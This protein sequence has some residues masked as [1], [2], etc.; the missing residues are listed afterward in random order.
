MHASIAKL[1]E[2]VNKLQIDDASDWFNRLF[3]SWGI[4]DWMT[5]ILKTA[6]I[7]V[8]SIVCLLL[9]L[10][11]ILQYIQWMIDHTVKAILVV[12]T[13]KEIVEDGYS[14]ISTMNSDMDIIQLVGRKPWE[15]KPEEEYR[16][17]GLRLSVKNKGLCV[18]ITQM[19]IIFVLPKRK[20]CLEIGTMYLKQQ[21]NL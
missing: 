13:E 12:N 15:E 11:C 20:L 1:K 2:G 14:D 7:V 5:S 9:I 6:F 4:R 8:L 10:P 21:K 18:L 16:T 3:Q 17:F 19:F